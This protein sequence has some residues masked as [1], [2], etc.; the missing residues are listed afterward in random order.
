M[1]QIKKLKQFKKK[2]GWSNMKLAIGVGVH[3]STMVF[4]MRGDYNPSDMAKEKIKKFLEN[5][6]E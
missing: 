1:N 2:S 5:P 4:W 3:L 6:G